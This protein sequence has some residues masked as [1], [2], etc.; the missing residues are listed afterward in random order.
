MSSA[1]HSVQFTNSNNNVDFDVH[2]FNTNTN[3]TNT[4]SFSDVFYQKGFE[5]S[6]TDAKATIEHVIDDFQNIFK[7]NIPYMGIDSAH[8]DG[9]NIRYYI[10]QNTWPIF[11]PDYS[12]SNWRENLAEN[13]CKYFEPQFN[14]NSKKNL[15]G[16]TVQVFYDGKSVTV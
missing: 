6:E 9:A 16:D 13:I 3:I 7:L 2:A 12:E 10:N 1:T 14:A 15:I 8:L 4:F 5:D 11:E